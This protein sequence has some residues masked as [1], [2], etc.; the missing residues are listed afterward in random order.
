[1]T[2]HDRLGPRPV[3]AP[4]PSEPLIAGPRWYR[5]RIRVLGPLLGLVPMALL[6]AV[7]WLSLRMGDGRESGMIGLVAGVSAAPGLLFVG[8]P[9][10]DDSQYPMA[11]LAS[12]PM[13]LLLGL[14]A[15]RRAT[16]IDG[17]LVARLLARDDVP[18]ARRRAR[19]DRRPRSRDVGARRI[20]SRLSLKAVQGQTVTRSRRE[21]SL[22]GPMPGTRSRSSTDA[23]GPLR[24]R[25]SMIA[26]A[27]AGPTPGN[28]SRS[29]AVAALR[30][31]GPAG[32]VV[33]PPAESTVGPLPLQKA[34]PPD[35]LHPEPAR[36]SAHHRRSAPPG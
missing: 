22:A 23:N 13:W 1:M 25:S 26:N 3:A 11:I 36:R 29:A 24:V 31:I 12:I 15:S 18:D 34:P 2:R 6:G 7:A 35:R 4:M 33:P 14:F 28:V 17:G 8:A 19:C 21:S 16:T 27:V 9:F 5:A 20:S 10:A 32:A 30:S